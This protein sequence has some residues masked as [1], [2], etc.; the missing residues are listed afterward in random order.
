ME[1]H[2]RVVN[3]SVAAGFGDAD[4]PA[5]GMTMLVTADGDQALAQEY[6]A[7]LA[8]LA[9]RLRRGLDT[10]LVMTPVE[11][12]IERAINAPRWPVILAD[13]GN[14]T[15]GGSPGDGTAILAGMKAAGWPD[16]ALFI[17]DE[18][19]VEAAW[20]AGVGAEF[21]AEVG[22]RN[23]PLNGPP[24][25]IRG[26]VRLLTLGEA[27]HVVGGPL[28]RMGKVA[29]VRCGETDVILTQYATSQTH[30]GYFRV[31][32]VEP[33]DR[34]IVV[35]QSAHLFREAFEVQEH[36]PKMIL[37][38]DSPGITS[39]NARRFTYHYVRRPIYP[40]D[41]FDWTRG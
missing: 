29:V 19:A 12:A 24:T 17:R 14:N 2:P 8:D 40:L 16:A 13:Q 21:D 38:V 25:A 26:V 7:E 35:V 32:G 33:R 4:T 5:T 3:V 10:E 37:E 27:R 36:I 18:A 1:R 34:R 31:V 6:A 30:P 41:D 22:G 15:A 23:E 28:A 11:T 39:P 9:W 20:A